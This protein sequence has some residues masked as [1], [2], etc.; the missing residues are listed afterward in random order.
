MGG[1]EIFVGRQRE[2]ERFQEVLADPAGQA[3]VVVGPAGMGKTWLL[4][5]MQRRACA[6]LLESIEQMME[7]LR[8]LDVEVD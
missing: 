3:V 6:V 1:N 2:L 7:Q 8:R 4:N 5:K